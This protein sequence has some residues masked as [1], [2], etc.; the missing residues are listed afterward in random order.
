MV[1]KKWADYGLTVM[2]YFDLDRNVRQRAAHY[3]FGVIS[4][5]QKAKLRIRREPELNVQ[6]N[7]FGDFS[8]CD[9]PH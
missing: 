7:A 9:R 3:R 1:R 8:F 6:I 5:D 2:K 4:K